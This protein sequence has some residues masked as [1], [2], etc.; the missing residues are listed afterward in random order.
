MGLK[1]TQIKNVDCVRVKY[2]EEN[3]WASTR[4][5]DYGKSA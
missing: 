4:V 3:I 5:K 2:A 1:L